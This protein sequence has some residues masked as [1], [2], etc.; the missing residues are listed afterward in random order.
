MP[1]EKE[2]NISDAWLSGYEYGTGYEDA[3]EEAEG[4]VWNE[5]IEAAAD[6]IQNEAAT[7]S[8][9]NADRRAGKYPGVPIMEN[10]A[11]RLHSHAA[12]IRKLKKL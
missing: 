7:I 9:L 10:E 12:S 3:L 11:E 5:A 4:R 6:I 2:Q 1:T 8:Q